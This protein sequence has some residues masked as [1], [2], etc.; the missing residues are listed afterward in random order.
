MAGASGAGLSSFTRH[1]LAVAALAQPVLDGIEMRVAVRIL[2]IERGAQ[3]RDLPD[4]LG[5]GQPGHVRLR[6]QTL[7]QPVAPLAPRLGR[8]ALR[9]LQEHLPVGEG[10]EPDVAQVLDQAATL[11]PGQLMPARA[12][13]HVE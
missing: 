11:I 9:R 13:A 12:D 4:R 2:R 10:L 8:E 1:L 7:P 6:R 5:Q 3:F